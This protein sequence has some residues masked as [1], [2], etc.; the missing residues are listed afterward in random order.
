MSQ[1][2]TNK[3][4][5]TDKSFQVCFS[6]VFFWSPD[7]TDL[8]FFDF[9]DFY[10]HKNL[11]KSLEQRKKEKKRHDRCPLSIQYKVCRIQRPQV[12]RAHFMGRRHG[13]KYSQSWSKHLINIEFLFHPFHKLSTVSWIYTTSIMLRE[14]QGTF[15]C[16]VC[17]E[18]SVW[19]TH[20][21]VQIKWMKSP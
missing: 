1:S 10:M 2:H 15:W 17:S 6:S 14:T 16:S 5:A 19:P 12:I 3:G 8:G 13:T 11:Y 7:G 20:S 4:G 18:T 9:Q 21:A